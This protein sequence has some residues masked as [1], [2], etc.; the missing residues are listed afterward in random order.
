M[1]PQIKCWLDMYHLEPTVEIL[2]YFEKVEEFNNQWLELTR[3]RPQVVRDA[4]ARL[5]EERLREFRRE[6]LKIKEDRAPSTLKP[7]L[8]SQLFGGK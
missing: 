7:G 6:Q 8:L 2:R 5:E 1:T 4:E 3:N